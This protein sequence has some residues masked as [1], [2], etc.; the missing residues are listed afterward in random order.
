MCAYYAFCRRA[1][2]IADGDYSHKL[3][4]ISSSLSSSVSSTP[5]QSLSLSPPSSSLS[6]EG[7]Q[8]IAL[9]LSSKYRKE[10]ERLLA[11]QGLY[12]IDDSHEYQ[13]KVERMAILLARDGV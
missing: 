3:E 9:H 10:V 13:D 11:E 12:P 2:D 1:D 7:E 6:S 8:D 4:Y 5:S